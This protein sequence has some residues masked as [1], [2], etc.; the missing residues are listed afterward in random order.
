MN[1]PSF[2]RSPVQVFSYGA[3]PR[4][5]A[6]H[7]RARLTEL[8]RTPEDIARME[9]ERYAGGLQ[10][11]RQGALARLAHCEAQNP[12]DHERLYDPFSAQGADLRHHLSWAQRAAEARTHIA[13]IDAEIE[14]VS[15]SR[16]G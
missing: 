5:E 14:R 10:R 3:D 11:E 8:E 6:A 4:Q 2:K 16:V 7:L 12:A 13:A 15:P 9:A 1:L